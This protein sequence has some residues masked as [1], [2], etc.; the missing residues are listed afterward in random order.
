MAKDNRILKALP[1]ST[2]LVAGL[3]LACL[4][5]SVVAIPGQRELALDYFKDRDFDQAAA[6]LD[7]LIANGDTS[8]ATTQELVALLTETD[9]AEV[10]IPVLEGYVG[11]HPEDADAHRQLSDRYA[12]AQLF[13]QQQRE[14]R[15]LQ[16]IEPDAVRQREIE[17][18]YLE[19]GDWNQRIAALKTM[20]RRF[21]GT[22]EDYVNLAELEAASGRLRDAVATLEELKSRHP[23]AYTEDAA[24]LSAQFEKAASGAG[25]K[26]AVTPV[27]AAPLQRDSLAT[28]WDREIESLSAVGEFDAALSRFETLCA[29]NPAAWLGDYGEAVSRGKASVRAASLLGVCVADA[30]RPLADRLAI[31]RVLVTLGGPGQAVP[32]LRDLALSLGGEADLIYVSALERDYRDRELG[33]FVLQRLAQ[34]DLS[35]ES[36]RKLAWWLLTS[37]DKSNAERAFR[38][39]AANEGPDGPDV[40]RLLRIW[41]SRAQASQVD[42]VINK[43]RA[44]PLSE[45][46]AWMRHLIATGEGDA[47]VELFNATLSPDDAMRNARLEALASQNKRAALGEAFDEDLAAEAANPQ[48]VRRAERFADL[49]ERARDADMPAQAER[50][51][52]AWVEIAPD[53]D[54]AHRLFGMVAMAAGDAAVAE[55]ELAL[56]HSK[57]AA[58]WETQSAAGEAAL[59]LD[60]KSEAKF[61]FAAALESL[62]RG[63]VRGTTAQIARAHLLF[64]LGRH[65]EAEAL[66]AQLTAERP[67]DLGLRAE[68]ANFLQDVGKPSKAYWIVATGL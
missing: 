58:D 31:A 13:D 56:W 16:E 5:A 14:L 55:R 49:C 34:A 2:L 63:G 53:E 43:A 57:G 17:R 12:D 21:D 25:D 52:G 64:R 23:E 68:W 4:A 42:W 10:V 44:A 7:E 65:E 37:G 45:R 59:A 40:E 1:N 6:I 38:A 15:A 35:I 11:A 20:I 8:V 66:F 30:G 24:E 22:P 50:A 48:A 26:T 19:K 54:Q 3:I 47:A 41:G 32:A 61:F 27:P 9:D 51:C 18:Y 28:Q 60:R 33:R 36:K 46:A 29:R 39:L 62:D 67:S